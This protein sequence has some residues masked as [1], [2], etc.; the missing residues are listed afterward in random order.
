LA[1]MIC[2][3]MPISRAA[4]SMSLDMVSAMKRLVGFDEQPHDF[5]PRD[6]V[7]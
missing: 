1:G 6:H 7:P 5:C 3:S 4:N 2:N